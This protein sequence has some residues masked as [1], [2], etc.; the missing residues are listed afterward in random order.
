[1]DEARI[2]SLKLLIKEKND[3]KAKE[4]LIKYFSEIEDF[5]ALKEIYHNQI[6]NNPQDTRALNNLA[7]IYSDYYKNY[8]KARIYYERILTINPNEPSVHYNYGELLEFNFHEYD[9]AKEHYLKTIELDANYID[10]YL[11]LS[12][13]YL[14]RLNDISTSYIVVIE[15]L[16]YVENSDIYTQIAYIEMMKYKD[17]QKAEKNFL[18]AIKLDEQNGLAYAYL[19]KLYILEKK[20]DD[21]L[22]IF[23]DA[24]NKEVMNERLIIEYSKLM[25]IHYKD[26]IGA[27]EILKKAI[28]FFS[29]SILYYAYIANLYFVLGDYDEAKNY[30]HQTEMFEIKNQEVLLMVGYLKVMLDEN[31]D[32]ALMYFE[33][34]IELNPSNLNALSFIGFYNL[35]NNQHIDTALSYFIKIADLSND[36]F[37]IHFIIAQIYLQYYHDSTQALEYLLKIKPESLNP[38]ELSHLYFVIGSIYEKY[39]KN[40]NLALDYYE[41][42]YQVKPDKNLE[43]IINRIYLS[44][45][46]II[47]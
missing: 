31:K 5:E 25:I 46:T 22:H 34:V 36:N 44:D 45:K 8:D 26:F 9:K 3:M 7:V 12:S 33:K 35:M 41:Q 37:I 29:D 21:A 32:E 38:T 10:A 40:N 27:I 43:D 2:Q 18:Q 1:M 39:V 19:G 16:K 30:L 6:K 15:A 20:Y 42:A 17:Y 47:N 4:E 23:K 11:N 24:L 13:L 14:E 28:L